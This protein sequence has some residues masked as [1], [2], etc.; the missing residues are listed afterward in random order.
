MGFSP[1]GG[2]GMAKAEQLESI[3]E[4]AALEEQQLELEEDVGRQSV[5]EGMKEE[6]NPLVSALKSE[7]KKI[8]TR[9]TTEKTTKSELKTPKPLT[10]KEATDLAESFERDNPLLKAK[11]LL[12]LLDKIN[13]QDS[14]ETILNIVFNQYLSLDQAAKALEFLSKATGGDLL[15]TVQESQKELLAPLNSITPKD[16]KDTILEKLNAYPHVALVNDALDHLLDQ[17]TGPLHKEVQLAKDELVTNHRRELAATTNIMGATQ[18]ESGN[19]EK[20]GLNLSPAELT[21]KYVNLTPQ[22]LDA[23]LSRMNHKQKIAYLKYILHAIGSDMTAEGPSIEHAK[24]QALYSQVLTLR[25]EISKDRICLVKMSFI[26]S[27]FAANELTIPP[28]L[29]HEALVRELTALT[30]ERY[31]TAEK[32]LQM[33]AKFG[34]ENDIEAQII[35]FSAIRD[36]IPQLAPKSFPSIEKMGEVKNAVIDALEKLED[37]L[38]ALEEQ[39]N[40]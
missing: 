10:A 19:L 37:K 6:G 11:D 12:A 2:A 1:I 33:A 22:S 38:E 17:T 5:E 28:Q 34:I 13:P 8:Q 39:Q 40:A 15:K 9:T 3:I 20:V 30:S 14:K 4:D 25:A 21:E 16:T 35:V 32:I 26:R 29:T 24:L 27:Q 7:Q 23:D 31:P 18:K 36:I